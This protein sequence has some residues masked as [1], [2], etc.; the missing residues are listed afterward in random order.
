MLWYSVV[1][2]YEAAPVSLCHHHAIASCH[3]PSTILL[4]SDHNTAV[5]SSPSVAYLTA[6]VLRA[7]VNENQLPVVCI[8]LY[9]ASDSFVERS[10]GIIDGY[11]DRDKSFAM[12]HRRIVDNVVDKAVEKS[13]SIS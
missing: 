9:Y 13:W 1:S 12:V 11:D 8:L 5:C 6:I 10:G 7:I 3:T 2:I 4:V